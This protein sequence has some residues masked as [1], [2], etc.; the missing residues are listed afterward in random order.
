MAESIVKYFKANPTLDT[1]VGHFNYVENLG[2]GG[3]ADVLMFNRAAHNFAIKFIPHSEGLSKIQRFR[4]EFFN[5]A[6]IQTHQNVVMAYHYDNRTINGVEYALIVMKAYDTTL[7]KMKHIAG[8]PAAEQEEKAWKLFSDLCRGLKHLHES[9]IIHRDLKPQNIFYDA[10]KDAFVIGDLGIAHFKDEEFAKLADTKPAERLANYQ[11]SAPE[12]VDSR[13]KITEAADIYSLGQVMQWYLTGNTVRGQGRTSFAKGLEKL[14]FLNEF[15]NKALRDRPLERFQSIAEIATFL[16]NKKT[17][18]VDPWTKINAFD[19]AIRMAFPSI[20]TSIEVTDLND[21]NSFFDHFQEMCTPSDFWYMLADGGDNEFKSIEFTGKRWLPF[22]EK[23]TWLFDNRDEISIR[24]LI[25]Y[26]D[27]GAPYKNFFIMLT[28][29]DKPFE[30][31]NADGK[32]IKRGSIEGWKE[33]VATLVDDKYYVDPN[34][35]A[36]GYIK[37][38]GQTVAITADRFQ[39]RIRYL[40]PWG[41]IVVPKQTATAVMSDRGPTSDFIQAIIKNGKLSETDLKEYLRITRGQHS[42]EITM[43][44]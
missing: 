24:K 22:L 19:K 32:K 1:D 17:P 3:N 27:N 10:K 8:A 20:R 25:V 12:Q 33:D 2:Q 36:N 14:E 5:A 18:F 13:N 6:Q 40:V 37:M 21:I 26:R 4:D 43:Y 16:D 42:R 41:I 9:H 11:F 31:C 34:S 28:A 7:H 44:T 15:A 38:R 23:R 30:L 29:E 39:D 35:T